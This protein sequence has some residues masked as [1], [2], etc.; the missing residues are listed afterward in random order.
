LFLSVAFSLLFRLICSAALL[1]KK[2]AGKARAD[3][4]FLPLYF[5]L[6][7]ICNS[8]YMHNMMLQNILLL[9]LFIVSSQSF[10]SPVLLSS[11][12][13][14][15]SSSSPISSSSSI[16]KARHFPSHLSASSTAEEEETKAS[17]DQSTKM[18]GGEGPE[19]YLLYGATTKDYDPLMLTKRAP[20]WVLWF[21]EAELKHARSAMLACVGL[22]VPEL[23][24]IPG[25]QFSFD[26]VPSAIDAYSSLPAAM[27][28]IFLAISLLE[29]M[30]IPVLANMNDYDRRPGDFSFDPFNLYPEDDEKQRVM[31]LNELK[32]GRL[33]MIAISGMITQAALTGNGFPFVN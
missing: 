30:S 2:Q 25:E 19:H 6:E 4:R 7:T 17:T 29:A 33:A 16:I 3:K 24:R 5:R 12:L 18:V 26:A 32:N 14:S 21:R 8:S 23:F 11:S 10:T 31:Q 28:Q 22:A 9:S 20:N 15:S 27:I 13:S 1:Y